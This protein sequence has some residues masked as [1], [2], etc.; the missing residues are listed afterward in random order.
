ME[1]LNSENLR[2]WLMANGLN[3]KSMFQIVAH[4]KPKKTL[5]IMEKY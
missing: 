3:Y 1:N 5:K 4:A 2:S